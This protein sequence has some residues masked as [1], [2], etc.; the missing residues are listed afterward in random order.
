MRSLPLRFGWFPLLV[1]AC[2]LGACGG[3]HDDL[4]KR[5]AS[6][7]ADLTKLQSHSDRL[8]QRLEVLEMRKESAP[9]PAR[10]VG[11]APPNP[12]RPPL[13][14]VKLEPSDAGREAPSD[15]PT[16]ALRPEDSAADQSPRPMIRVYGSRTDVGSISDNS[17]HKR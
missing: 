8:E 11:E 16:A 4:S 17:K 9:P 3:G 13:L 7:Q 6:V 14:V 2:C 12:E 15:A 10:P 1:A 5:L